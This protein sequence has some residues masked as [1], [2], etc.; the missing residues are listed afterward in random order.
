MANQQDMAAASSV[1]AWK[2]RTSLVGVIASDSDLARAVRLHRPPDIFELRLDSL[3]PLNAAIEHKIA[4]L[5]TPLIATARHPREGGQN[6]LSAKQR[7][8]LLLRFLPLA[9]FVDVELRSA[10]PQ[11]GVLEAANAAQVKRIISWHNLDRTPSLQAL[12][13]IARRAEKLAPD[14]LKIV[15]R[16]DRREDM[17]RLL[18]FFDRE[19]ARLPLCVMGVGR[20]GRQSRIALTR[21]G[22]LFHYVH[23]GTAVVAGQFSLASA[24]Q[25]HRPIH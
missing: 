4:R 22:I 8:D 21:R 2:Q 9:S 13:R 20:L 23:L 5:R 10:G 18:E 12:Q 25:L 6:A 11:E 14:I 19:C 15:T 3:Y 24:R 17:E 16:T 7:R 1:K